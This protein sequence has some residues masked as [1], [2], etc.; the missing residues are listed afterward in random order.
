MV[1]KSLNASK[2]LKGIDYKIR[3]GVLTICDQAFQSKKL[4][5][6][7]L[8]DSVVA[9]G[10][11]AFANNDDM[12]YC[13]IPSSVKFIYDNNPWGGCFSIIEMDCKSPFFRIKDGILYSSDYDI[14]Y[15]L[16]YWTPN[17]VINP[18]T[19]RISSN[20]FWSSRKKYLPFH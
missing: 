6:I 15:G 4:H 19:K 3:E 14:L 8:P 20:A 5:S 2:D 17:I 10:D 9:I 12:E 16:I 13:N 1:E 7:T 18:L 11:R